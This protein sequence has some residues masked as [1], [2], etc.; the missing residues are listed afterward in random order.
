M[1]VDIIIH[2][3]PH[4]RRPFRIDVDRWPSLEDP[5][6][7]RKVVS[8]WQVEGRPTRCVPRRRSSRCGAGIGNMRPLAGRSRCVDGF[9]ALGWHVGPKSDAVTARD[10]ARILSRIF[11]HFDGRGIV[12]EKERLAQS[13]ISRPTGLRRRSH[14]TESCEILWRSQP[15]DTS[16]PCDGRPRSYGPF[17]GRRS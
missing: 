5:I 12:R 1:L 8:S 16:M 14:A 17:S 13:A 10:P 7:R 4:F 15:D 9:C 3:I 2:A 11:A 6:Y